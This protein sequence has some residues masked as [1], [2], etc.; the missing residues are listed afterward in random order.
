[1]KLEANKVVSAIG[2]SLGNLVAAT[3]QLKVLSVGVL[4][5]DKKKIIISTNW[6]NFIGLPAGTPITEKLVD[7]A[8]VVSPARL[9]DI[10]VKKVYKRGYKDGRADESL[11][12][13][14]SQKIINPVIGDAEYVHIV[15]EKD[16]VTIR[17]VFDQKTFM[18]AELRCK[19]VSRSAEGLFTDVP[20]LVSVVREVR[21]G[22]VRIDVAPEFMG[23]SEELLLQLQL[24]RMGYQCLRMGNV[25]TATHRH[26]RDIERVLTECEAKALI[27]PVEMRFD[28]DN[29][30]G[31]FAACTAGV[32]V[33]A[34]EQEGFKTSSVLEWRPHEK[35][36]LKEVKDPVTGEVSLKINDKSETGALCAVMNAKHIKYLFNEDIYKF[37]KAYVKPFIISE[38]VFHVSAQC[39]DFSSLKTLEE[40][41][42]AIDSLETTRDMVFDILKMIEWVKYPTVMLENVANFSNSVE[43]KLF[44][45]RLGELG[46]RVYV[47]VLNAKD[48]NGYTTRKRTFVFATRLDALF[49]WPAA[50]ERTAHF[51]NDLVVGKM[52]GL[53]DVSHTSSVKKGKQTGRIRLAGVGDDL[54]PTLTKSQNRQ[55]K[56][57][58]Y[59]F[60]DGSYYLPEIDIV[61]AMMGLD[62]GFN[63]HFLSKELQTEIVG[64]AV[65]VP[66]HKR[67][68]DSVKSH[69]VSFC[70]GVKSVKAVYAE[71]FLDYHKG[72]QL[73]L[74]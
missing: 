48:Y 59:V 19:V 1:M 10:G 74:F 14:R 6:L 62:D 56:D 21:A 12:D 52:S 39:D 40:R 34:S 55:V 29:P 8:I 42:L 11:L 23:S 31:M 15:F 20:G 49:E 68:M 67:I 37:D 13:T 41:Q 5:R 58:F 30:L 46:Y 54:A 38:N 44:C 25:I 18:D 16:K 60:L 7:G 63:M 71:T 66:M 57:S 9:G 32:D 27:A 70:E 33:Y 47:K 69:I 17:P 4:N 36:D 2:L 35:R 73:S 64:Q 51:F 65:D 53:R 45:S 43:N 22:I 72:Q 28:Y 50:V 61:K 24:R 26:C 3:K